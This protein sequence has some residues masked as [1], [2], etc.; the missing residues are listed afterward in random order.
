MYRDDRRNRR[1]ALGPLFVRIRHEVRIR[2]VVLDVLIRERSWGG[3]GI[4]LHKTL[5]LTAEAIRKQLEICR[6][7]GWCGETAY[8]PPDRIPVN[9]A[10]AW[11]GPVQD[12]RFESGQRIQ[13]RRCIGG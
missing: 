6:H 13:A 3:C 9:L 10:D 11:R 2:G 5:G 7:A 4:A 8:G 12:H 1:A